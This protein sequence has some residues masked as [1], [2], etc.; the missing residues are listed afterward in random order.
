M[1]TRDRIIDAAEQ[2]IREF[3]IS[4][5]T[6]KRIAAQAGCS[7]ALLYKHFA[8]K[9]ALFLAVLLERMPALAPALTRLRLSAGQ[10]D[11]AADLARFAVS[12]VEFYTK[13]ATIASGMLADP[14]L[15]ASFRHMLA[16]SDTGPHLPILALA[17]ILAAEQRAGRVDAG[18]DA[19]AAASMLMGACY[20]RANLSY[21]VDPDQKDEEWA[22]VLVATL[23]R[24]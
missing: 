17:Q 14:S 1:S 6:T 12:A 18:L 11:L 7:E 23:L 19:G 3:G 21:F 16:A 22:A 9:E 15:L 8:G 20:H 24:R 13:A 4:G 5:A 2:A 10:G